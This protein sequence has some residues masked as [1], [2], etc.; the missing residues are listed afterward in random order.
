MKNL[1]KIAKEKAA[2]ESEKNP[3][4]PAQGEAPAGEGKQSGE[5]PP[6]PEEEKKKKRGGQEKYI[7]PASPPE[8]YSDMDVCRLL[9]R[10][11]RSLMM[12][13]KR[14][15][16]GEDWDCVEHHAGMTRD[17][18]L[19]Q[20]PK[21]A[22]SKIEKWQI[23]PGDGVVS[24]EVVQHTRDIQKLVCRRLSDGATVV[25]LVPDAAD[26]MDGEQMDVEESGGKYR[27]KASMNQ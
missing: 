27:W 25:V 9:G 6:A 13:R 26:F 21:A 2:A 24:V 23:Q 17:W 3:P 8:I 18:I 7:R 15:G 4:A 11:R 10:N 19:R 12:A 22:I 5:N 14:K 1:M 16:R 20:N